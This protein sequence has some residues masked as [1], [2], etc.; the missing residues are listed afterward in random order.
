MT[1]V[2]K[3]MKNRNLI[4]D[5][6][7]LNET[8]GTHSILDKHR[9]A[10]APIAR[11]NE[12]KFGV[13]Y[14]L[15]AGDLVELLEPKSRPPQWLKTSN[16]KILNASLAMRRAGWRGIYFT[17]YNRYNAR[18]LLLYRLFRRLI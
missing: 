17:L 3:G 10:L 2:K 14:P 4:E 18:W 6:L 9:V 12:G 8:D 5:L 11:G 1:M 13:V 16:V 15:A 7:E